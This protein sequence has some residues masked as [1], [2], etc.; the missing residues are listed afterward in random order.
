MSLA[1]LLH[2]L[3]RSTSTRLE[4][5]GLSMASAPVAAVPQAPPRAMFAG[6]SGELTDVYQAAAARILAG[7]E[8]IFAYTAKR[9]PKTCY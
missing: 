8:S 1:E 5:A 3:K 7:H 4:S 9:N 6:G 2:R